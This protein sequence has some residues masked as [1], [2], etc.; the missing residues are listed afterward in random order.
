MD[1]KEK[2]KVRGNK[3]GEGVEKGEKERRGDI[4]GKGGKVKEKCSNCALSYIVGGSY[5]LFTL[6]TDTQDRHVGCS[7]SFTSSSSAASVSGFRGRIIAADYRDYRTQSY[8]YRSPSVCK[9]IRG[10]TLRCGATLTDYAGQRQDCY[11]PCVDA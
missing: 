8:R 10:V 1:G 3:G 6:T 7:L 9:R 4:G 5:P 11:H 2:L